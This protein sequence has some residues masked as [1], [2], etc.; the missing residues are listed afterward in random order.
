M[1]DRSAPESRGEHRSSFFS[2]RF[3]NARACALIASATLICFAATSQGRADNSNADF[4][5]WQTGRKPDFALRDIDDKVLRLSSLR[6]RIVFLHFFATWCEPCRDELPALDRLVAR[7]RSSKISVVAISVAE[8]PERVRRFFEKE[9][10]ALN[11]PVL[12]DQ[13]RATTRTWGVQI[14][15]STIVLDSKLSPRLVV[16]SDYAWDNLDISKLLTRLSNTQNQSIDPK[17]EIV[18]YDRQ[19][20]RRPK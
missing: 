14:L 1:L 3:A 16:A 4:E 10:L 11:F 9:K 5:K 17:R 15:P 13:D 20:Q 19:P 8:V 7:D 12:L 18:S 6:G 2:N